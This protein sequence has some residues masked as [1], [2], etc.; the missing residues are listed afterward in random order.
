MNHALYT[1]RILIVA[2]VAPLIIA[3]VAIA[4]GFSVAARLPGNIPVHWDLAGH[5]NGY[6]S[7]YQL[8]I[9]FVAVCVPIIA[10]FG[11]I[12]V[13]W[14]HRGPLT[15]LAKILAISSVFVTVVLGVTFTGVLLNQSMGAHPLTLLGTTVAIGI[16]AAAGA[17]FALPRG[18][19]GVA[20]SARPAEAP[21]VLSPDERASWIRST[22]ASRSVIWT[23]V[24]IGVVLSGGTVLATV[25]TGGQYWAVSFL[26]LALILL[27][28]SMF[29]WT[30]R[31]DA[32]GVIIRAAL[33]IP[34]FRI[35]LDQI[36]S[37]N[38][39]D[40]QALA[41]YGGWGI[42]IAFNSRIGIIVRSGEALEIHRRKGL[43]ML[44]TIEDATTAAAL[45][46]GLV[47]QRSGSMP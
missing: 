10:I 23:L 36:I 3:G 34:L 9:V 12:V 45:I 22:S 13:L 46:N 39:S 5:V 30:V 15:L 2:L 38:A 17:W 35:P 8:P 1:A 37:A 14:S 40:V 4:V 6:G 24:A 44:V 33:G 26:P 43:T 21:V 31:V 7:P 32:R 28:L 25:S 47:T 20:G 42:R 41:Q 11:G 18:V 29:A 19:R 27:S 16:V